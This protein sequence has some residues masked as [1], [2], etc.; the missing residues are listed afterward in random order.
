MFNLIISETPNRCMPPQQIAKR[1]GRMLSPSASVFMSRFI[2]AFSSCS[3]NVALALLQSPSKVA[4]VP[5]AARC[6]HRAITALAASLMRS[7]IAK[8]PVN[9]R[10]SLDLTP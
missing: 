1:T 6:L 5:R 8:T 2:N 10:L 3:P 9:S 7:P 4:A